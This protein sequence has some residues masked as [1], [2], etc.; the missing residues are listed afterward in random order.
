MKL[1]TRV[2]NS[3]LTLMGYF[4]EGFVLELSKCYEYSM[5]EKRTFWRIDNNG[6]TV[7]TLNR[8]KAE[9]MKEARAYIRKKWRNC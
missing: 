6:Y 3:E 8:T 9:A 2:I 1:E 4:K 5:G 7:S